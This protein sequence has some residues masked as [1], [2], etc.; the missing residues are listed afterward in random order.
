VELFG[1]DNQSEVQL[2]TVL[3]DIVKI[4]DVQQEQ[5][6]RSLGEGHRVIHGVAGSGK[7]LILGY[8][9]LYLAKTMGKPILVLCFNVTL[10]A[11]LRSFISS[12]GIDSQVQVYHFHDWCTQQIKTYHVDLIESNK[13]YYVRTVETVIN[14]VEEGLIPRAQYGALL[15]DEGHDFDAEW[16]KLV[17]QMTDPESQSL[18]LLYDDAQSIYKGGTGLGFNLSSVGV[19]AKG[20]T[21]ILKLNYR[22][23]REI[24]DFAYAFARQYFDPHD[25][26]DDHIPLI[27]PEAAGMNGPDPAIRSFA[28]LQEEINYAIECLAKWNKQGVQWA[29]MAILYPTINVG[30]M[31]VNQLSTSNL[32]YAWLKDKQNKTAYNKESDCLTVLTIH[33]SKGLEFTRVIIVGVGVGHLKDDEKR[34]QQ[35]A[36][37]LYVGMTRAQECLLVTTS[38]SN[39]YSKRILTI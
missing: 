23:T 9:C 20:R 24:L 10:A 35:N 7:T 21:T 31:I 18:L 14:A 1:S 37:L 8:R 32:P 2:D 5:L 26:D 34:R 4:M 16:L 39:D 25:A 36:R 29:D 15:I 38:G 33:S 13:P 3:P 30:K 22:N 19:Q 6:A 28:S 17:V 27:E 11:K 12:K